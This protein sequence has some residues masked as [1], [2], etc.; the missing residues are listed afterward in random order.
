MLR[1]KE[2]QALRPSHEEERRLR[3]RGP[4]ASD[5]SPRGNLWRGERRAKEHRE[6]NRGG[7]VAGSVKDRVK[8]EDAITC[9]WKASRVVD[10]V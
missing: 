9:R 3:G 10:I 6:P 8:P 1:P 5:D 2:A 4:S 7:K